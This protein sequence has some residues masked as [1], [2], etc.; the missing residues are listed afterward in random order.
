M[1]QNRRFER[2]L[3]TLRDPAPLNQTYVTMQILTSHFVKFHASSIFYVELLC[4]GAKEQT[5]KVEVR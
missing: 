1:M 3:F 2:S 5:A 4:I